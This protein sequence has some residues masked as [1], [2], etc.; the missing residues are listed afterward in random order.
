MKIKDCSTSLRGRYSSNLLLYLLRN[1]V[2]QSLV[3]HCN[4]KRQLGRTG[5][6]QGNPAMKAC[7]TV[8][9]TP[10]LVIRSITVG[11]TG[12]NYHKWGLHIPWGHVVILQLLLFFLGTGEILLWLDNNL[13]SSQDFPAC[14]LFYTFGYNFLTFWTWCLETS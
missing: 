12:G 8:C 9:A 3:L 5:V 14:P 1:E 2:E 7:P 4:A 6:V 11:V 13:L 10:I